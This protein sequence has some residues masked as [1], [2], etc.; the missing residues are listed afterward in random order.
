MRQRA[1]IRRRRQVTTPRPRRGGDDDSLDSLSA[2]R[3]AKFRRAGPPSEVRRDREP[4][5]HPT[6]LWEFP[7]QHYEL[8]GGSTMQGDKDYAGATPGW[9][10]WE[11]LERWTKPGDTV[12]D[13]MCGSGTSLDVCADTKRRGLGFDLV[14]RRSDI[15]TADARKLPVADAAVDFVFIDPP[16]STHITYST[17]GDCIGQLDAI[18]DGGRNYFAAMRQV[19]AECLRVL[20]TGGHLAIFVSDSC[21][22][23]RF[24]PIGA[25]LFE[26][27][28]A[29]AE[30]IEWVCVSRQNRKLASEPYQRAAQE[31]GQMLRGFSHLM[32]FRRGAKVGGSAPGRPRR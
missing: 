7:A 29:D 9:V 13:P 27:A 19:I 28:A 11:C 31:R 30:P 26:M 4:A 20:R 16:Y 2:E 24:A 8:P 23:G 18:T 25:R 1:N 14:S 22:D 17:H 32:V 10:I 21:G 3:M 12:L 15:T 5:R 6:T